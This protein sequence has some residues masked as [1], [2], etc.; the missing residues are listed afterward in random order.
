MTWLTINLASEV[1]G[2]EVLVDIAVDV[3]SPNDPA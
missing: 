2:I 3:A 1:A